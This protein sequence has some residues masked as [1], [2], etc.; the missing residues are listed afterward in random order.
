M[1]ACSPHIYS[2]VSVFYSDAWKFL[3]VKSTVLVCSNVRKFRPYFI[4]RYMY[5]SSVGNKLPLTNSQFQDIEHRPSTARPVMQQNSYNPARRC[6]SKIIDTKGRRRRKKQ[7]PSLIGKMDFTLCKTKKLAIKD[8]KEPHYSNSQTS[9][10]MVN[11][12][13]Q[14][15]ERGYSRNYSDALTPSGR[16]DAGF[17]EI[18]PRI[19]E[20]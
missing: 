16:S 4:K 13:T 1:R 18:I 9:D 7:V 15:H 19:K 6:S 5:C 3:S 17:C 12:K 20:G 10:R 2:T 8:L 11:D 14:S